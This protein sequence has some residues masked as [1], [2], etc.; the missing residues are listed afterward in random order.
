MNY[1]LNLL[2]INSGSNFNLNDI[3]DKNIFILAISELNIDN[4]TEQLKYMISK[5][6]LNKHLMLNENSMLIIMSN[7]VNNNSKN[8]L[9]N[10]FKMNLKN[11]NPSVLYLFKN[12]FGDIFYNKFV[13]EN[14]II[15]NYYYLTNDIQNNNNITNS[16]DKFIILNDK[17]KNKKA[18]IVKKTG[19][20][21]NRFTKINDN[22][23]FN[24]TN[25]R[26][27]LRENVIKNKIFTLKNING[28]RKCPTK[29]I[30][31]NNEK[32][33]NSSDLNPFLVLQNID[34]LVVLRLEETYE[35]LLNCDAN[36][37]LEI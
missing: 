11:N 7:N 27:E 2:N 18:F 19:N 15:N 10:L 8:L 24:L 25:T 26:S 1:D 9:F 12:G 16:N 21:K 33:P 4:L 23:I 29:I 22:K 17:Y 34:C 13:K 5:G 31:T 14:I 36:K 35:P 37:L 28:K 30:N 6:V 20:T 3:Q 32:W